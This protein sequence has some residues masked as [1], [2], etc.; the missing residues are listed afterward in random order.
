MQQSI[1]YIITA[2]KNG[3]TETLKK[4]HYSYMDIHAS[5]TAKK[6]DSFTIVGE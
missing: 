2:T 6:Y 1:K 4:E 3:K 5:L